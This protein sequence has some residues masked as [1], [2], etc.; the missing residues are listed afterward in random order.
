MKIFK[1]NISVLIADD[2][3]V[4]R[5][6]ISKL[7]EG[8]QY[9]SKIYEADNG[10][11]TVKVITEHKP[12]I[13][14]LDVQM[15]GLDGFGVINN[16][17]TDKMPLVIFSTAYDHYAVKAFEANAVDYLVKPYE[18]DRFFNALEKAYEKINDDIRINTRLKKIIKSLGKEQKYL[19]RIV[20]KT[21]GKYLLLDVSKVMWLEAA[22]DYIKVHL[23]NEYFVIRDRM[24]EIEAKL[25]PD[26]FVRIHRS[27]IININFVKEFS[28]I[29]PK[30]C[31]VKLTDGRK[32]KLS[33][34][35]KQNF[36]SLLD[37]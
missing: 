26:I 22:S 4:A 33:P 18:N 35:Y 14:I 13:V 11:E 20:V 34:M 24:R 21:S 12:D 3:P 1:E 8:V 28:Q 16:I 6:I 29:S 23:K 9:V 36:M 32:I 15:P 27:N 37:F 31:L 17:G 19:E 5:S 25:N 30:I 2:E 10:L 7:L